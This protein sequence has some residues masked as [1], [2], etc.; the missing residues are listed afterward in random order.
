RQDFAVKNPAAFHLGVNL[1][2][3]DALHAI[4][5]FLH[6]APRPHRH[7]RVVLLPHALRPV[8][9]ECEEIKATDLVGAVVGTEARPHTTLIDHLVESIGTMDRRYHGA[10]ILARSVLAVH[11]RHGLKVIFRGPLKWPRDV[12]INAKPMHL[13][14]G[15]HLILANHRNVVL[16]LA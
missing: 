1:R 14:A 3:P 8:I 10:N 4:T 7:V 16:G 12:A 9:A 15:G 2:V 5:A 11:A 13:A 6:D